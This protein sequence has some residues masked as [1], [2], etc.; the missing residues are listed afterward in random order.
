MTRYIRY[1]RVRCSYERS[2][3]AARTAPVADPDYDS[4]AAAGDQYAAALEP[5]LTDFVD[6][7]IQQNPLL[8]LQE[9]PVGKDT[10]VDDASNTERMTPKELPETL[11]GEFAADPADGWQPEGGEDSDRAV[12]FGGEPQ[13]W[14]GRNG[15]F[16]GEGRPRLDQTAT[17]PCTLREHLLEQIGADLHDQGDRVIAWHLLHS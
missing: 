14:H 11:T 5:W 3:P 4:S 1:T 16:D 10:P 2:L 9:R 6:A 13:P 12:D 7:E 8:E 15:S 17:R